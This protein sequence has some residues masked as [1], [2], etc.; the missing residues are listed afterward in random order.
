MINEQLELNLKLLL[1]EILLTWMS[2][3]QHLLLPKLYLLDKYGIK[4]LF[5][6]E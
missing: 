5:I 2:F 6:L 4:L 3:Q 1:V